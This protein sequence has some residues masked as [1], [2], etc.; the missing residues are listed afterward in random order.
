M[1]LGEKNVDA[2]K[3]AY[4]LHEKHGEEQRMTI[5]SDIENQGQDAIKKYL[6]NIFSNALFG[7]D[8]TETGQNRE[9]HPE[10]NSIELDNKTQIKHEG[11]SLMLEVFFV[12]VN[13]HKFHGHGV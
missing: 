7:S 10:S 4:E 5:P 6:D 11:K 1:Y 2:E 9:V 13:L 3:S 8:L 12:F